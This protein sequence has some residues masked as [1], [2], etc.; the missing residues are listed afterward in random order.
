VTGIEKVIPD[1]DSACAEN[2][3]Q[4]VDKAS[5]SEE[6]AENN[7]S[8]QISPLEVEDIPLLIQAL[9]K[10]EWARFFSEDELH[11]FG[12]LFKKLV[13][14]GDT[15]VLG[16]GK[17]G[18]ALILV[19]RGM[20]SVRKSDEHGNDYEEAQLGLGDIF[21][22]ES[23]LLE[24]PR[25]ADFWAVQDSLLFYLQRK[26]CM[27]HFLLH[28]EVVDALRVLAEHRIADGYRRREEDGGELW[29]E[30]KALSLSPKYFPL[31][32]STFTQTDFS[33]RFSNDERICLRGHFRILPV[34]KGTITIRI[35]KS[36]F[37]FFVV[38][39]G[40]MAHTQGT[41][42]GE[43]LVV[44]EY[45]PGDYFGEYS[46]LKNVPRQANFVALENSVLFCLPRDEFQRCFISNQLVK[47]TLMRKLEERK[48]APA[49]KNE[50]SLSLHCIEQREKKMLPEDLQMALNVIRTT[51][52]FE[53]MDRKYLREILSRLQAVQYP[54]GARIAEDND[55]KA[56]YIIAEGAVAVLGKRGQRSE[57]VIEKLK[58]G[59]FFGENELLEDSPELRTYYSDGVSVLYLLKYEDFK[60]FIAK[61]FASRLVIQIAARNKNTRFRKK[62]PSGKFENERQDLQ[63]R[64]A[65]K[66]YM[67]AGSIFALMVRAVCSLL[68][69]LLYLAVN[70]RYLH[71]IIWIYLSEFN[72]ALYG[73][74]RY[75]MNKFREALGNLRRVISLITISNI[76]A[77]G[78]RMN[79]MAKRIS[80]QETRCCRALNLAIFTRQMAIMMDVGLGMKRTFN[81]LSNQT[82]DRNLAY[83]LDIMQKDILLRGIPLSVS[84]KRFPRIFNELYI[85][86]VKAG[87]VSGRMSDSLHRIANYLER[88]IKLKA[89]LKAAM[90]YPVM[91]FM[92]CVLLLLILTIFVMPTFVS[93][94]EDL[95]MTLPFPTL[96]IIILFNGVR[97]PLTL[98]TVITII[99]LAVNSF[100]GY[101]RTQQG[102]RLVDSIIVHTSPVG[103]LMKKVFIT[104]FCWTLASLVDGGISMMESLKT[105]ASVITNVYMRE[106]IERCSYWILEGKSLTEA[107]A[108]VKILPTM[109]KDLVMVGEESGMLPEQLRKARDYY[110]TEINYSIDT[111][112][113]LIEPFL[114]VVMG[115]VIGFVLISLFVPIYSIVRNF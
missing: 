33:H 110:D 93:L 2:E 24:R 92:T 51:D 109:L 22:E 73:N 104:R 50:H 55:E 91:I 88:D 86:L 23:V 53:F 83:A 63:R 77:L 62:L 34:H 100:A 67:T 45:C 112:T 95:D 101:Y 43:D 26:E 75:T 46:L 105:S 108:T 61:D 12:L 65:G 6:S 39:T 89:K 52:L 7:K 40:K 90:T 113:A 31:F 36:G 4:A 98:L 106:Q 44:R 74:C 99:I 103:D 114:I 64:L 59:D 11:C 21:G 58:V 82:D 60:N 81:V 37:F 10:N 87:E 70:I 32:D 42:E 28:P 78:A 27:T 20:I 29:I 76:D 3:A 19:A 30:K 66:L 38:A 96:M 35:G 102:R 13:V 71:L 49:K 15:R 94:F 18:N 69:S 47:N 97:D 84:M 68:D 9:K 85:N 5:E 41:A 111:F 48:T 1:E 54:P 14:R 80:P 56:F 16:R 57:R 107:F 25:N 8:R 17:R 79:R 115:L 72:R